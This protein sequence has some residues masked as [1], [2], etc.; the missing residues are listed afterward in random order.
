MVRVCVQYALP[1]FRR[2]CCACACVRACVRACV[3][4]R[5][6]AK[7]MQ[8][9]ELGDELQELEA[10][11][12]DPNGSPEI[13]AVEERLAA[14]KKTVKSLQY[15]ILFVRSSVRRRT[16]Q[17]DK[18]VFTLAWCRKIQCRVC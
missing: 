7:S 11:C 15:V 1:L 16:H 5:Y 13:V 18:P 14:L 6:L 3:P 8:V 2:V 9:D 10:T 17:P 4:A 12:V